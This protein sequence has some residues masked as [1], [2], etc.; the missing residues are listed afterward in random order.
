MRVRVWINGPSGPSHD[1]EL[2]AAPRT[3]ERITIAIGG[4]TEEGIVTSVSWQLQGIERAGDDLAID[5]QPVG[6]VAMVHILCHRDAA[7]LDLGAARAQIEEPSQATTLGQLEA[8]EPG[9]NERGQSARPHR[10]SLSTSRAHSPASRR[11]RGREGGA[12]EYDDL[13]QIKNVAANFSNV[14]DVLIFWQSDY[15][16]FLCE[17][18]I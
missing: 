7:V 18:P 9:S 11:S 14:A 16:L 5:G 8:R 3:G 4:E 17:R 1:F 6:S 10:A 13:R 15:Y 2:V 12:L